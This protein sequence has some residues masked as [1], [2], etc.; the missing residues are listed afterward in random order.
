MLLSDENNVQSHLFLFMFEFS[1]MYKKCFSKKQ[2]VLSK[3]FKVSKKN[4]INENKGIIKCGSMPKS[5]L[6]EINPV[7]HTEQMTQTIY[8]MNSAYFESSESACVNLYIKL[9]QILEQDIF[10]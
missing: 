8:S 4:N 6:H 3:L 9:W 7:P 2:L 1:I 5:H 10:N